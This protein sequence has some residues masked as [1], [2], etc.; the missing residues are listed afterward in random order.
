MILIQLKVVT[1]YTYKARNTL[2]FLDHSKIIM[3][4]LFYFRA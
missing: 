4:R 3:A 1:S 2:D